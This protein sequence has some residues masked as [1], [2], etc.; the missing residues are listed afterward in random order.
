MP[1]LGEK[2]RGDT[3]GKTGTAA[4]RWFCWV[5]CERCMDEDGYHEPEDGL[6]RGHW[7]GRRGGR[8]AQ[9]QNTHRLCG[10]HA[11]GGNWRYNLNLSSGDR[12]PLHR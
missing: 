7:A 10:P 8:Y 4:K 1:D 2:A 5:Q 12:P 9:A 11:Y 3:I 6:D